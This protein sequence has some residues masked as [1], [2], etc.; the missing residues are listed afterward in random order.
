MWV[1]KGKLEEECQKMSWS[2]IIDP[3][4]TSTKFLQ[5]QMLPQDIESLYSE[6]LG[7]YK[8]RVPM[9]WPQQCCDSDEGKKAGKQDLESYGTH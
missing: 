5:V 1:S 9:I 2:E 3:V 8:A 4:G 6:I 7:E